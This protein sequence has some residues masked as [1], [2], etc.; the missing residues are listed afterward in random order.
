MLHNNLPCFIH[1]ENF[2]DKLILNIEAETFYFPNMFCH[3][4][5]ILK[6]KINHS[7]KEKYR[8]TLLIKQLQHLSNVLIEI[9][10]YKL[11]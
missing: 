7:S 11:S 3:S 8:K 5:N 10:I 2:T 6:N 9:N 4:P 1:I